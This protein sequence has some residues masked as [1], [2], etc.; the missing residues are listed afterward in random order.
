MK[1]TAQQAN[2][3]TGAVWLLGLG[4]LIVTGWWWPGIM[5]LIGISSVVQGLV[6]GQGWYAWQGGLWTFGI[7]VW[8]LF[9]YNMLVFFGLVALSGLLAA[10]VRP[11][12]LTKKPPTDVSLE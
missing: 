6:W 3:V 4:V 8:A 1:M 2:A 5:F 11:P 12:V 7:G 9:D 10:F